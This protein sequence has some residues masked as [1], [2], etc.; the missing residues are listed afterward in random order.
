ML[1]YCRLLYR[2]DRNYTEAIKCYKC[3][4]R[5]DKEN[6]QIMR[7]LALLQVGIFH[8]AQRCCHLH[9]MQLCAVCPAPQH[10]MIRLD[11]RL[12][13]HALQIQMRDI[14]GFVETRHQLLQLKS[15][16]KGNWIG[17]AVAHHLNGNHALAVQILD[18]FQNTQGENPEGEDYELS[19]MVMYKAMILREGGNPEQALELLQSHEVWLHAEICGH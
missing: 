13:A 5:M 17:F 1:H 15:N 2:A 12:D 7:D 3:A 19:E 9:C 14:P 18:S 16:A 11:V 8:S 4:L 10:L 6:L